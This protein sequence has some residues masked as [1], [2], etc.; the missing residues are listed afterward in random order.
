MIDDE[1]DP[2]LLAFATCITK[3]LLGTRDITY[4]TF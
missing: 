4:S 2:S 3:L 1:D